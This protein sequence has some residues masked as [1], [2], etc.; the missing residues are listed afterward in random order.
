MEGT[1]TLLAVPCMNSIDTEFAACFI[2]AKDEIMKKRKIGYS[3]TRSSLVYD[4]RNLLVKEAM[5]GGYDRILFIDSDMSFDNDMFLRLS[6]DMDEGLEYVCGIFFKR[7]IPTGPCIYKGMLYDDT[8]TLPECRL[9]TYW[10]YPQDQVFQVAGSG[11]A[12]T[13]IDLEVFEKLVKAGECFPFSPYIG[14]GEDVSFCMRLNK[15]GIKMYCDSR[16]KVDHIGKFGIGEKQ[17]KQQIKAG[18]IPDGL[19]NEKENPARY[20]EDAEKKA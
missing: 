13:L 2:D 20:S 15:L 1:K 10:N 4:A 6:E 7:T 5:E 14:L 17:Y 8:K 3:F 16:V 18:M 11:T 19:K 12:A 9:D